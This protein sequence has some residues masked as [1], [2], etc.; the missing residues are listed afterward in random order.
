MGEAARASYS[1]VPDRGFYINLFRLHVA[2]NKLYRRT[3]DKETKMVKGKGKRGGWKG[4]RG[5]PGK[6]ATLGFL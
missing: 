5:A 2:G 1:S 3:Y 4:E 6:T